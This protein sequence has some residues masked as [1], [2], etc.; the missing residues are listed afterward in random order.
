MWRDHVKEGRLSAFINL[1]KTGTQW[2]MKNY[3]RKVGLCSPFFVRL[4][5]SL[6]VLRETSRGRII[7]GL[8]CQSVQ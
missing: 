3:S 2:P 4:Q 7:L 8:Y 6:Q 5:F 1:L